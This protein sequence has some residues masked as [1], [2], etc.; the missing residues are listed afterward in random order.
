MENFSPAPA[1]VD[2]TAATI[3]QLKK[4]TADDKAS[5]VFVF[6]GS[7]HACSGIYNMH[8]HLQYSA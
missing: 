6:T 4:S 1:V 7:V 2:L 5:D 8:V 3:Q